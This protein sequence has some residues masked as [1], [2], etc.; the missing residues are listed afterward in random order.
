MFIKEIFHYIKDKLSFHPPEKSYPWD[1][2][3]ELE[4][5]LSL[6]EDLE[7]IGLNFLGKIR[8]I[9]PVKKLIL[10]LYDQDLGKFKVS[11][12]FGFE[13]VE[14]KNL[15]FSRNE[16]LIKWLKVNE[17]YFYLRDNPGV[18]DYLTKK[19]KDILKSLS[20]ELCFPLIAM[21]RFIGII[22]I[23][24]KE[25]KEKF[26]KQE[27]SLISALTPQIGIAL[28]NAVLYQEQ[29]EKFRR[30]SRADRLATAGE[31][32]AGAAHEI[33]NPLTAIKSCLQYLEKNN[34]LIEKDKNIIKNAL[35]EANRINDILSA[36]LSFARPSEI[37]K[38]KINL[39]E[40]LK[41]SLDLISF[42][43]KKQK[44]EIYREFPSSHFFLKG[45]ESQLKQLFLNLFLNSLQ[46]MDKGGELHIEVILPQERQIMIIISDT[47]QGITEENLD[48]IF[49]PFYTTKKGGTGLGL[50]ICYSIV[51]VHHGEIEI[52]SN[53]GEGTTVS[54]AFHST[55]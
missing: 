34:A 7:Q 37:Q 3:K 35:Q 38:E 43:A 16:P 10:L 32:A 18:L 45:D 22:L 27:L 6:I 42:Q 26:D 5:S 39:V 13:A 12:F 20:I 29:R 55:I 50:S 19:E 4:H 44:V 1:L 49:D 51:K 36:L 54:L 11:N 31:L 17:T 2:L 28:E 46:A 47:G 30:M 25:M 21:N 53:I 23:G 24:L 33:R 48:K 14:L 52:K 9:V 15:S 40:T 8:E 41:K